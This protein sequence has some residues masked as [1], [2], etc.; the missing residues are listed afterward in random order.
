MSLS[1]LTDPGRVCMY[2]Y[3]CVCVPMRYLGVTAQRGHSSTSQ[4]ALQD[5]VKAV[6]SWQSV[7]VNDKEEKTKKTTLITM[8]T[9]TLKPHTVNHMC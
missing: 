7:S 8:V 9:N 3:V 1:A 5:K 2:R 4:W 6:D